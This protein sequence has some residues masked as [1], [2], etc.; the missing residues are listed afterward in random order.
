MG[1][2]RRKGKK[3]REMGGDFEGLGMVFW[4]VWNIKKLVL[5][6]LNVR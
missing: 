6:F 4:G 3:G 2:K 1:E 5:R